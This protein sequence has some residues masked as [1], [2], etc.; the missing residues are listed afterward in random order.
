MVINHTDEEKKSFLIKLAKDYYSQGD[1]Y[2]AF[3]NKK[4]KWHFGY[5]NDYPMQ[6]GCGSDTIIP[7]AMVNILMSYIDKSAITKQ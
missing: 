6:H 5:T 4:D 1:S 3:K 2:F 7:D